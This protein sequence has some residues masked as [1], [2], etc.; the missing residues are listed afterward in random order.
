VT[1]GI[2]VI[3]EEGACLLVDSSRR[4]YKADGTTEDAIVDDK[5]MCA[6]AA[7]DLDV[8]LVAVHSGGSP[9]TRRPKSLPDNLGNVFTAAEDVWKSLTNVRWANCVPLLERSSTHEALVCGG[10]AGEPVQLIRFGTDLN[11]P[12]VA[13]QGELYC[14]GALGSGI[15][16]PAPTP[17]NMAEALTACLF[18]ATKM[19]RAAEAAHLQSGQSACVAWPLHVALVGTERI[20]YH[21][22]GDGA[23]SRALALAMS[24]SRW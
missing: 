10:V 1:L 9:I 16:H 14:I 7:T 15:L 4:I 18:Q 8:R 17:M 12:C 21:T 22:Y 20:D 2:G 13:R 3:C 23:Y 5:M 24:P 11:V 19:M 6:E